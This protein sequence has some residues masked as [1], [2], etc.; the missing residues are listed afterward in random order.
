MVIIKRKIVQH[1]PSTLI[2]SLPSRWVKAHNLKKGDEL[3]VKEEENSVIVSTEKGKTLSNVNVDVTDLDRTSLMRLIRSLYKLGYHEV[4]LNFKHQMITHLR[5]EKERPVISVVHEEVNKLSG[6]E[7]IQQREKSCL[8]KA[9]SV[10]DYS[11]F[12]TVLRRIF[13]LVIDASNDLLK[14]AEKRD[15]VLLSTVV[16]EK[17][18]TIIKFS[19]FCI[20]LLHVRGYKD[21]KKTLSLHH[22]LSVMDRVIDKLRAVAWNLIYLKPAI[23]KNARQTMEDLHQMIR[24]FYE[25]FYKFE[26]SKVHQIFELRYKVRKEIRRNYNDLSKK[27]IVIVAQLEGL[28]GLVVDMVESRMA[29]EY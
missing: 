15:E 5:L 20:R 21:N 22:I 6:L 8:L 4:D 3:E 2:I 23:S 16:N 12:E 14:G 19:S 11:E 27:E 24:Y 17:H 10:M 25:L 28:I 1:G 18:D 29:M 13:L 7:V 26:N 9:L